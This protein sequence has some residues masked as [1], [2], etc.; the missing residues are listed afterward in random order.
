MAI[1]VILRKLSTSFQYL[2]SAMFL[3]TPSANPQGSVR[4]SMD[5]GREGPVNDYIKVLAYRTSF[6]FT[7]K[8]VTL[9][10]AHT[11]DLRPAFS[12][13]G[14]AHTRLYC[15]GIG[16]RKRAGVMFH[17]MIKSDGLVSQGPWRDLA[18]WR[19]RLSERCLFFLLV[20]LYFYSTKLSRI[21]KDVRDDR[22]S[23]FIQSLRSAA[24]FLSIVIISP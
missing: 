6:S 16:W 18:V 11:L 12:F 3:S 1:D 9:D 10:G 19:L 22:F 21:A 17:K 15:G 4:S 23:N 7:S 13:P 5:C 2:L 20:Q 14:P 8:V 24:Y